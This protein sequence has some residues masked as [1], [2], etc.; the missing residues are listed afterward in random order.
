M[1]HVVNNARGQ[2]SIWPAERPAPAGWTVVS[3]AQPRELCLQYIEQH[4]TDI[5]P[6]PCEAP[7]PDPEMRSGSARSIKDARESLHR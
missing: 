1:F 4:W 7:C 6:H 3:P 5:R 2:Y